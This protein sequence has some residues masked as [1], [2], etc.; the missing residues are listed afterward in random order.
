MAHLVSVDGY[1]LAQQRLAEH[2]LQVGGRR[3]RWRPHL[4]TNEQCRMQNFRQRARTCSSK[5]MSAHN[6]AMLVLPKAGMKRRK[7]DGRLTVT[8]QRAVKDFAMSRYQD[9]TRT[10]AGISREYCV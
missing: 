2:S 6:L 3:G 9:I 7:E 5:M 8:Q 4:H 1:S 10:C